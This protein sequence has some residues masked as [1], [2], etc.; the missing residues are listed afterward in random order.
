MKIAKRRY[1]MTLR[2]EKA[3][4][5]RRRIVDSAMAL[6]SDRPIED[7]TLDEIAE[8]AGTT[9]QTVLRAYGSKESLLIAALH[10]FA[11]GGASLK[12]TPP[13]DVPAAI[14]AIYDLYEA[15]GDLLIQ[16]L[17]D[18]RRRPATKPELDAGRANHRAWVEKIFTPLVEGEPKAV[19]RLTLDAITAATDVYVWQK[20]RRD[21]GLNRNAAERVVRRLIMGGMR[22]EET[23]GEYSVAQLVRR[24]E[25]AA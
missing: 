7:F 23:G 15:M 16:R 6:Y 14:S 12:P 1:S 18:E 13:G 19:R 25:S 20:L 9:V 22:E 5:T 8:R 3:A 24:R 2:A 11:E 10:R 21:M 17:G 4:E